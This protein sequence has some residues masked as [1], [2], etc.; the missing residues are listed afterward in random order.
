MK[1][2]LLLAILLIAS[3]AVLGQE[4]QAGI[5]V[6]YSKSEGTG[7]GAGLGLRFDLVL[8]VQDF[9][10]VVAEGQWQHEPKLYLGDGSGSA[11]RGRVESRVYFADQ[12]TV[13]VVPF[14]TVGV[15]G[16][17]QTTSQYTKS[18]TNWTAGAGV[19]ID[20]R[21]VGYWR[22][23]FPEGQTQNRVNAD[24]FGGEFYLP[25]N[26]TRWRFRAGLAGVNTRFIQPT[27][28][29]AGKVNVWSFQ[30]HFGIGRVF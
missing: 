18:A 2:L 29:L 14:A 22:H 15:S 24:E 9:F 21:F 10:A 26:D 16:V 4:R 30:G 27:G 6:V 28:P 11:W 5:G 25:L 20:Q 23:F 17:H 19:V 8:P 3:V 7:N 13:P 1:N 12:A